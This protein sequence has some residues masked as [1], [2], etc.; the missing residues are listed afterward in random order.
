[1][2]ETCL[3]ATEP[4]V[5]RLHRCPLVV[6]ASRRDCQVTGP[7]FFVTCIF[8]HGCRCFFSLKLRLVIGGTATLSELHHMACYIVHTDTHALTLVDKHTKAA[9]RAETK[10]ALRVLILGKYRRLSVAF[11]LMSFTELFRLVQGT[12][13][14]TKS[15]SH[16][17]QMCKKAQLTLST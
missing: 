17:L 7:L 6:W 10:R 3:K 5:R 13:T 16:N 8:S 2:R 1:M 9:D 14:T 4:S 12:Q 15:L 11:K